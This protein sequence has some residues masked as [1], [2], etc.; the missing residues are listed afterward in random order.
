MS[1]ENVELP[2]DTKLE[3]N[4]WAI[5]RQ[6]DR[7]I[8]NVPAKLGVANLIETGPGPDGKA[9]GVVVVVL[10]AAK[11]EQTYGKLVKMLF[12]VRDFNDQRQAV[13]SP[14]VIADAAL[15]KTLH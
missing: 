6:G 7:V 11:D 9:G 2:K 8:V 3:G 10:D 15:A 13:A 4:A 1:G 5:E 12:N 14:I